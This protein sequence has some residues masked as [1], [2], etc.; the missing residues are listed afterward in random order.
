MK[1]RFLLKIRARMCLV[2]WVCNV[3]DLLILYDLAASELTYGLV[4]SG[5]EF[6]ELKGYPV[7]YWKL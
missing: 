5:Q 7:I 6:A 4:S 1:M 3:C 2:L